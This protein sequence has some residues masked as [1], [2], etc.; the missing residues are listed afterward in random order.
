[1]VSVV[2]CQEI[3]GRRNVERQ[4]DAES[5]NHPE[6]ETVKKAGKGVIPSVERGIWVGASV[7]FRKRSRLPDPSLD[8]RDD[9]RRDPEERVSRP[10][11]VGAMVTGN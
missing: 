1:M 9:I 5:K 7:R 4:A 2:S 11:A 6:R 3:S 10:S 8:A